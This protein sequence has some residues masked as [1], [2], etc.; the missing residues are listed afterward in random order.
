MHKGYVEVHK[1]QAQVQKALVQ[2]R[3]TLANYRTPRKP[4][5]GKVQRLS[6]HQYIRLVLLDLLVRRHTSQRVLSSQVSSKSFEASST[7]SSMASSSIVE[8]A[9][10]QLCRSPRLQRLW[11][12]PSRG[13][14]V[15]GS[16]EFEAPDALEDPV[17]PTSVF[18]SFLEYSRAW[19]PLEELSRWL[20]E[21][22]RGLPAALGELKRLPGGFEWP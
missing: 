9:S 14:R 3:K 8:A 12:Q 17:A 13:S 20:Q 2:V 22:R 18:S 19:R 7:G 11:A 21:A 1:A 5:P 10:R 4:S 6:K 16:S 15:S